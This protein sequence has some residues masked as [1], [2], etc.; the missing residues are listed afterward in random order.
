MTDRVK[1]LYV[2]LDKDYRTDDVEHIMNAIRMVKGVHT[3]DH[4]GM[5]SDFDDY[6]NR[7]RAAMEL[8]P[9]IIEFLDKLRQVR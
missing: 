5:V 3:V 4:E 2:V 1:G 9:I 6:A 7:Q 8:Q